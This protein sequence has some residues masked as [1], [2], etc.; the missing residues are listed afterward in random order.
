MD[1]DLAPVLR[2]RCPHCGDVYEELEREMQHPEAEDDEEPYTQEGRLA[3][4]PSCEG[5]VAVDLLVLDAD[6]IWVITPDE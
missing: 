6:G 2:I 1:S 3:E 4:C 5:T